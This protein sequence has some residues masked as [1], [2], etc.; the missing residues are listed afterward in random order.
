MLEI[1]YLLTDAE[2]IFYRDQIRSLLGLPEYPRDTYIDPDTP[3]NDH[4]PEDYL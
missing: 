1:P 3:L 2:F 4:D